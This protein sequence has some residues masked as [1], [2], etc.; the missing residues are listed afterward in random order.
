MSKKALRD[1]WESFIDNHIEYPTIRNK[2]ARLKFSHGRIVPDGKSFKYVR[3]HFPN[4][5]KEFEREMG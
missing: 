3:A 1:Q 5:L 2:M 4:L